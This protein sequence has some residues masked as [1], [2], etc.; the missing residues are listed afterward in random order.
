MG[1]EAGAKWMQ[2]HHGDTNEK[3]DHIGEANEMV[4]DEVEK[5]L[6]DEINY[7]YHETGSLTSEKIVRRAFSIGLKAKEKYRWTDE[8]VIRIVE[9][10]RETG[11]TAEYLIQS[12]KQQ[13]QQDL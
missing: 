9:K 10:S 11:L 13:K 2:N 6:N 8:D 12:L 1:F 5:L 4:E 3:I 7:W